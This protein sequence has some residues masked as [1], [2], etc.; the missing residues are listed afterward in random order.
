MPLNNLKQ[1]MV[2]EGYVIVPN[3][4]GTAP[5]YACRRAA[6]HIVVLPGVPAR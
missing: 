2:P 1:A 4:L 6:K 3:P 5:G